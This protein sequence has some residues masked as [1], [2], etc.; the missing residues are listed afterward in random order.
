MI[1]IPICGR[2]IIIDNCNRQ[3]CVGAKCIKYRTRKQFDIAYE[4]VMEI[5]RYCEEKITKK[6]EVLDVEK[7]GE[8][9]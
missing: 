5:A 4:V 1:A 9:I 8:G 6:K 2:S 3:I 7:K